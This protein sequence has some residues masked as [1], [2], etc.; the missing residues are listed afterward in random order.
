MQGVFV[1]VSWGKVLDGEEMLEEASMLLWDIWEARN[2]LIFENKVQTPEGLVALVTAHLREYQC[3]TRP[4]V[5]AIDRSRME[6][7]G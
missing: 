4:N 1:N 5:D 6:E 7:P 2:Q 3:V